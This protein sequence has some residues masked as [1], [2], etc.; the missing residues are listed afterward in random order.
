MV[1]TCSKYRRTWIGT[2]AMVGSCEGAG[3]GYGVESFGASIAM[4]PS[5]MLARTVASVESPVVLPGEGSVEITVERPD[6]PFRP[7]HASARL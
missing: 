1:V 6:V 3:H 4:R 2:G 5:W 7:T